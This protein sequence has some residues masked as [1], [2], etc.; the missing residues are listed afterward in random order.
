MS[1]LQLLS[2]KRA[3]AEEVRAE[4]S[5][6]PQACPHDGEPLQAGPDGTLHCPFDGYRWPS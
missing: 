6:P 2:I 1:W 5:Q 3:A 4:R